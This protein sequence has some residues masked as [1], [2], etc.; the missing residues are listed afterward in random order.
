MR[1]IRKLIIVGLAAFGAYR[2]YELARTRAHIA[3]PPLNDALDTIK[4][5]AG[6]VKT[7][8]SDAQTDIVDD[9]KPAVAPEPAEAPGEP[10]LAVA[11]GQTGPAESFG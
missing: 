6:K 3:A 8:L 10:R 1:W 9:L 4:E 5:T 7:D 11:D 2:I